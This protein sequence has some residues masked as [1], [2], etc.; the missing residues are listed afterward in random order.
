MKQAD[1]DA[2]YR[3]EWQAFSAWLTE[4]AKPARRRASTE[5]AAADIP[6]RYRRLC[7]HLALA[8]DRH[9]S[10]GLIDELHRLVLAGHRQLYGARE[11]D[12]WA[13]QRFLRVDVPTLF[14]QHGRYNLLAALL[15]FGPLFVTL[16]A[17]QFHPDLVSYLLPS[18][19]IHQMEQM[20]QPG[21]EV[22]G[23][24]READSDVMMWGFYIWNNVRIDFQCFAT[25]LLFGI[26]S[27]FFLVY[28]GI[29][30]G[31]VA[32]H[33]TRIGY[34]TTFW[35][36]VA[37]HSSFELMGV[38]LSGASGL[39]LGHALISPGGMTRTAALKTRA[40]SAIR[41]LMGAALLTA[42]AAFV[43]AFWSPQTWIPPAV[44][45]GVGILFW[46]LLLLHLL[47]SGRARRAA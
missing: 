2:H 46:S 31:A 35:S 19:T 44:K 32:G 36:F 28:N 4:S 30:I 37:G 42:T 20:Y 41:L 6:A 11:R 18:E 33:L 39:M 10:P 13:W 9:Y 40:K 15:F 17:L 38:V 12:L 24:P 26:G 1:F 25:G 47:Q 29:V 23:Y 34:T 16:I 43:E 8:R 22:H 45:Y 7:Q 14:R 21:N 3:P 27:I 5:L